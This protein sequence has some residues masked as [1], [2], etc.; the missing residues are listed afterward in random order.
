MRVKM[1]AVEAPPVISDA[2]TISTVAS[3]AD[4]VT[5]LTV[6]VIVNYGNVAH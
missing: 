6:R 4:M 3:K 1:E 2:F 5:S